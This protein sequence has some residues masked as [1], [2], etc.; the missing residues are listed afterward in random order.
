MP[1]FAATPGNICCTT[2]SLKEVLLC[3]SSKPLTGSTARLCFVHDR[4]SH[5]HIGIPLTPQN[6]DLVSSF[7]LFLS[8]HLVVL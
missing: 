4:D 2:K 7:V 3:M 1:L 6:F 5:F 8:R